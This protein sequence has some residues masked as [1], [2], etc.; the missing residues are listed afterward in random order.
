MDFGVTQD[1]ASIE[2]SL[3]LVFLSLCI[4]IYAFSYFKKD[5]ELTRFSLLLGFFIFF[6]LLMINT[7]S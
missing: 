5:P 6:M 3:I 1:L 4:Q 2:F 7:S